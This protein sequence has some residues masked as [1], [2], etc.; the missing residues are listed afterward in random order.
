MILACADQY[1]KHPGTLIEQAFLP[2]LRCLSAAQ[3]FSWLRMPWVTWM[4]RSIIIALDEQQADVVLE[5]LLPYPELE[6]ASEDIVASIANRW[7]WLV[8]DFLERRQ[9]FKLAGQASADY[10]AVPF[11]LHGL[12]T[13]LAAAP[14]L[15]LEGSRRWFD[16]DSLHFPYDGGRLLAS[17]FPDL[18]NGL[19]ARL[20]QLISDGNEDDLAFA[21]AILS[22]FE[23]KEVVYD[24]VRSIVA[25]LDVD[26]PLFKKAKHVL[27]ESGVV[28][29]EF[30]FAEL[31]AQ[32]KAL[33][34]PWLRDESET[35]RAFA[36]SQIR[37]LEQQIA[38]EVRAAEASIASRRL[39]YGEDL[40]EV[41]ERAP[42]A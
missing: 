4:N 19:S 32:R 3:D 30:G 26:S 40:D 27:Q 15:M 28:S 17:V 42:R 25:V 18:A 34:L 10:D 31:H 8:I 37:D 9:T 1:D 38:A 41:E 29:G 16:A 12:R 11:S 22:A 2:A 5:A 7:P 36:A 13:P 33:L 20:A 23:G 35:V 6:Y 24:H 21:L 14:D 39:N